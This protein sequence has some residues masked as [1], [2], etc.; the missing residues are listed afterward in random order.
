MYR[1]VPGTGI[2]PVRSRLRGIFLLATA[3]A[4][5]PC[6]S[7]GVWTF[8]LPFFGATRAS[9][10]QAGAVKSLH[11]PKEPALRPTS[12]LRPLDRGDAAILDSLVPADPTF[13]PD[14]GKR[15][16]IARAEDRRSLRRISL[17]EVVLAAPSLRHPGVDGDLKA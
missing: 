13:A 8:S 4:A 1:L 14:G 6:G 2:E 16:R 10:G 12:H 15:R 17:L 3:F 11:F 5:E 7:F 9:K